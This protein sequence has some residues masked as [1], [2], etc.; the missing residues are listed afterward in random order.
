MTHSSL[1]ADL[2]A[3]ALLGTERRPFS[4]PPTEGALG[5]ALGQIDIADQ[6]G[7]LLGAAATIR[8]YQRAGW[9]PP[10]Y[11]GP[12]AA[13]CGREDRPACTPAATQHL[14]AMLSGTHRALLPEWLAALAASGR[15]IANALLPEILELGR[16][17]S[18]LREAILPC[19]GERG[20]W[21]AAQ[22]ADWGYAATELPGPSERAEADS[23]SAQSS[24][25][26]TAWE[27]GSRAA[28]LTLLGEVR[29]TT[30]ALAHDM[31]GAT[32]ATE[33]ADD[34]A[35]FLAT[36]AT[37]LSMDDEPFL[38][39]ALDD[40]SKEV[41]RTAAELLA[42]LPE[43]RLAQRMLARVLPLLSYVSGEKP[44][45]LALR[46]G[47]HARLEVVLPQAC[48]KAMIR[49]G[50]EPKPPAY[51]HNLGEKAWWLL[52]MLRAVPP[53]TWSQQWS[54]TPAELL[55]SAQQGE[56]SALLQEAWAAAT[57]AF[58]DSLWAEELLRAD[59]HSADL[60][61][62]LAPERQEALLLTMLRGDC[63]PLHKHPV[64]EILR[65]T[66]H[67]WSA[68]LT[69]AV[70]SAI[71]RHMR[72]WKDSY[73][74]QLRGA[75]TEHFARRISPSMIE[76]IAAGW[77]ADKEVRE[78]WQ[79]VIERLLIVLQFRRDMLREL[80]AGQR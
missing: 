37:S 55:K 75:I 69:R 59:P 68:E 9:R 52:Q 41:R 20:R 40:R 77:P 15:R 72:T 22:N 46:P 33:K 13:I 5:A 10:G 44:R 48:D 57:L 6:E 62:A 11:D 53:A 42:R 51:R 65:Q 76:E 43:S 8:L 66:H 23:L 3:A 61:G 32:W 38:E 18:E 80:A 49:D 39:A 35:A 36:F 71:Y 47:Q 17:Q 50:V 2:V 67:A 24:A 60:L 1:W 56:W 27:T 12:P 45:L 21:L 14:S 58:R 54:A 79:G 30:P 19:L 25:L 28:R 64:L 31:L 73:D 26:G 70:L 78:R 16:T 63:T 74:Y 29:K 34:R 7:A 4:L